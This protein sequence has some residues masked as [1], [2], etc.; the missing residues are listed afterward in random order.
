MGVSTNLAYE[1]LADRAKNDPEEMERVKA[2][3]KAWVVKALGIIHSLNELEDSP[4][5]HRIK[6]P[7]EEYDKYSQ[8]V[9]GEGQLVNSLKIVLEN[10]LL[11]VKNQEECVKIIDAYW[12][13]LRSLFPDAFRYPKK[14]V[15]QKTTGIFTLHLLL[16]NLLPRI[17]TEGKELDE[18]NFREVL[19]ELFSRCG[20]VIG[21]GTEH[22]NS[23][24]WA[25]GTDGA[26]IYRGQ[27]GFKQLY[28]E[29]VE[30]GLDEVV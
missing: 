6:M 15:I 27:A 8:A 7:N 4:W 19:K 22:E 17:M 28:T 12:K 16:N 11:Q 13:A 5:Y 9:A 29:L 18:K 3:N 10:G 14:H 2:D 1:L 25:S 20:N 23:K 21:F 26:A 24:F 30:E